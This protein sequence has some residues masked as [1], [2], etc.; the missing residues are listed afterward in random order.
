MKPTLLVMAAGIGSRYGGLKQMDTFGPNGEYLIEYAIYDAIQA[1]FG[2]VVF[3]IRHWFEED[4]KNLITSRFDKKIEV[5]YAFQEME[6]VPEGVAIPEGRQKPYGTGHAIWVARDVVDGP[7]AVINADDFYGRKSYQIIADFLRDCDGNGTGKNASLG[8]VLRNTLTPNG[9]CAR[10][11][12]DVTADGYMKGVVEHTKIEMRG[13]GA[14]SIDDAGNQTPLTGD[15]VTSMNIWGFE[16]SLFKHLEV[17]FRD[18]MA[19]LTNPVKQEFYITT[20]VD[21]L[22]HEKL[23]TVKVLPTPETWFGVTYSQD[24]PVVAQKLRELVATGVYPNKLW[25]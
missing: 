5:G 13:R 1:G 24:K 12:C 19:N 22:L 3:I 7:F 25:E 8:F 17:Y 10:G 2:K 20:A 9:S 16:P 18:F 11:I 6:L 14:V 4:F 15:E 21:R 23:C